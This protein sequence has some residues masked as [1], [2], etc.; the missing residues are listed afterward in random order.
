MRHASACYTCCAALLLCAAG[1]GRAA[2]ISGPVVDPANGH[3]YLLLDTKNWTGSEAEAESLGGHLAT[4]RNA[5]ENS[6]IFNTFA[7]AGGVPRNL[8]IGF[9]DAGHKGIYTWVSGESVTY[10]NWG[11]GQPDNYNGIE[12][13]VHIL[14]SQFQ[15]LL[16]GTWNDVNDNDNTVPRFGVVEITPEPSAAAAALPGLA[17]LLLVRRRTPTNTI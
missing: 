4:V 11:A 1:P 16:P 2:V 17:V 10:T 9:N 6:F 13:Y 12:D 15:A 3:K 14:A 8:W 5:A 7:D